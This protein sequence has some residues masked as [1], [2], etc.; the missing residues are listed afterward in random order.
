MVPL[1]RVVHT[2]THTYLAT[3]NLRNVNEGPV[4]LQQIGVEAAKEVAEADSAEFARFLETNVLGSLIFTREMS[5]AMKT[6]EPR[7]VDTALP[8]RGT[9]RG[10]IVNMGSL[11]SFVSSPSMIQYTTSKFAVLGLSKNAGTWPLFYFIFFFS[12]SAT[13]K[14]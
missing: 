2:Y 12:W 10:A 1:P 11:A 8:A 5:A 6:Q 9:T 3:G 13:A 14:C 4:L 7:P